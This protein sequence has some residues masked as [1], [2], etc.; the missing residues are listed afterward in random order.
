MT[1]GVVIHV[2]WERE[3]PA[4]PE[5]LGALDEMRPT[6]ARIE[7]PWAA[8]QPSA[9]RWSWA[10]TDQLI[11]ALRMRGCRIVGILGYW[12]HWTT[13]YSPEA[14]RDFGKYAEAVS[15]RYRQDVDAWEVWNE[16]NNTTYWQSTPRGYVSLLRAAYVGVKS[17]APGAM[18]L[19]G[20]LSG[21]DLGYLQ[22]L[23]DA[24]AAS[25]MDALSVH[26]YTFG[27]LPEHSLLREELRGMSDSMARAGKDRRIWVTEFGIPGNGQHH[28]QVMARSSAL[29][30]QSQVVA[31]FFWYCLGPTGPGPYVL[32]RPDGTPK[33]AVS[34]LAEVRRQT[35]G[36]TAAGSALPADHTTPWGAGSP[37]SHAGSQSWLFSDGARI[38]RVTWVAGGESQ[39]GD[40]AN[41]RTYSSPPTW[42][43]FA[44]N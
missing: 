12:S 31:G 26:P 30:R 43:E 3:D 5:I 23:L 36:W 32:F 19:G 38:R 39:V 29:A 6:W 15:R 11:R 13:P 22:Q 16:P 18:V 35:E 7:V 17:G 21:A 34:S 8:V 24:G 44:G 42:E 10:R 41:S 28:A 2:D 25:T 14:I 37:V 1:D 20:S 40:G 27:W 33:P 9:D 4:S